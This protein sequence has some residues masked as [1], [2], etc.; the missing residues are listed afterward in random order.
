MRL[1]VHLCRA[2]VEPADK[3]IAAF[4]DR[5]LSCL[6]QEGAWSLVEPQAAWNGN[7]TAQDFVAYGWSMQEGNN[8]VVVVN[9]SDHQSQCRLRLPFAD[10]G[11]RRLRL[12]DMMGSEIYDRDGNEMEGPGLFIDLAPWRYNVFRLEPV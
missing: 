1:P 7:P 8:L 4:Y 10:L 2:P 12:T 9:Y 11:G 3:E 5:L 6:P